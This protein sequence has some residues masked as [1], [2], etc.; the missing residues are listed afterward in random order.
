MRDF[1][2]QPW[3]RNFHM[4]W[5]TCFNLSFVARHAR[6]EFPTQP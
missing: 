5:L 1:A 4:L 3:K 6:D 2:Q